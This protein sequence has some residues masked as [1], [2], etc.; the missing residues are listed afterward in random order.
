MVETA[1]IEELRAA[2]R[3]DGFEA[4][5]RRH[6]ATEW[7]WYLLLVEEMAGV[8]P[9]KDGYVVAG[10]FET[11]EEALGAVS[12]AKQLDGRGIVDRLFEYRQKF[13]NER[14]FRGQKFGLTEKR[15]VFGWQN[16]VEW[17]VVVDDLGCAKVA[18]PFRTE[19]EAVEQT[20]RIV[21]QRERERIEAERYQAAQRLEQVRQQLPL[22]GINLET[23]SPRTNA[24]GDAVT[25]V[26]SYSKELSVPNG[27]RSGLILCGAVGAGKTQLACALAESLALAGTITRYTAA[28]EVIR[29][30]HDGGDALP[31][32]QRAAML[33][34][35]GVGVPASSDPQLRQL[36]EIVTAL[37]AHEVFSLFASRR[38]AEPRRPTIL[39]ADCSERE[40]RNQLG[41]HIYEQVKHDSWTVIELR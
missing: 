24:Q 8:S 40:L 6:G 1:A 5:R 33:I 27:S 4:R 20:F 7:K 17:N 25:R 34:V 15:R 18:G 22:T 37:S 12:R 13:D 16:D 19:E 29:A 36:A 21:E 14:W 9:P 26:L 41:E 38:S 28:I 23:Y 35:D 32:L 39:L 3:K 2:A 30:N 11:E 31:E 10:P